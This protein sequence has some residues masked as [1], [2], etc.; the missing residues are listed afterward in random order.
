MCH[1][2]FADGTTTSFTTEIDAT[3][4]TTKMNMGSYSDWISYDP[5]YIGGSWST[6]RTGNGCKPTCTIKQ[7]DCITPTSIST[8]D[9]ELTDAST[10]PPFQ[11]NVKQYFTSS[12]TTFDVCISCT[13]PAMTVKTT[14][15]EVIV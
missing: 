5:F 4:G 7:A 11:L 15:F 9:L 13:N 14:A 1:F 8:N 2:I 12:P 3:V 6:S 10:T